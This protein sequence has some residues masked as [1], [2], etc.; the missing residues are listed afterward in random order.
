MVK[1]RVL[2]ENE[3]LVPVTNLNTM[4]RFFMMGEHTNYL[5]S[6]RTDNLMYYTEHHVALET[7][8]RKMTDG[9]RAAMDQVV[10]G[11]EPGP[12]D[13]IKPIPQN[14]LKKFADLEKYLDDLPSISMVAKDDKVLKYLGVSQRNFAKA[15]RASFGI[16]PANVQIFHADELVLKSINE[17]RNYARLIVGDKTQANLL[18]TFLLDISANF[19]API[20]F[21]LKDT[22]VP[23]FLPS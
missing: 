7:R 13:I 4:Q 2:D 5:I 14:A 17:F 6:G 22:A 10:F 23:P 12:K 21:N 20:S 8:T 18:P 19:F 15:V 3:K 11:Y 9:F 16:M 1:V